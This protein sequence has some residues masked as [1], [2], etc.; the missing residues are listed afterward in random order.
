MDLR[1]CFL[2]EDFM[3]GFA[4]T[5]SSDA[6]FVNCGAGAAFDGVAIDFTSDSRQLFRVTR[7]GVE[8]LV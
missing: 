2:A 4:A 6:V 8:S 1:R 3:T 5:I 7:M